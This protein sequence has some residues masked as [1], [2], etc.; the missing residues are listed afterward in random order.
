M[1]SGKHCLHFVFR[2]ERARSTV[3]PQP[4][5]TGEPQQARGGEGRPRGHGRVV[6]AG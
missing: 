4:Q 3:D 6:A 5:R 2:V 1:V